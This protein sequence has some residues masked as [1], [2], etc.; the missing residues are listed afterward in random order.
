MSMGMRARM[1][2]MPM[3]RKMH[4]KPMIDQHRMWRTEVIVSVSVKIGW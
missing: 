3:R 1:G 2:M 4:Q